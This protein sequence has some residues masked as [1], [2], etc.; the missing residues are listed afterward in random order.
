MKKIIYLIGLSI[1]FVISCAKEESMVFPKSNNGS[2][3]NTTR[4]FRDMSDEA[5]EADLIAFINK[6]DAP[7]GKAPMEIDEAL[8][9]IEATLNYKYVNLDYSKCQET[10]EFEGTQSIVPDSSGQLSMSAIAALYSNIKDDWH[11]KYASI[12]VE[13]KT[14]VAFDITGITNNVVNYVMMVGHGSLD[15][16]AYR[17]DFTPQVWDFI[18]AANNMSWRMIASLTGVQENQPRPYYITTGTAFLGIKGP[19]NPNDPTPGDGIIDY[20]RYYCDS[21]LHGNHFWL[22]IFEY[23]YHEAMYFS[24]VSTFV[25]ALSLSTGY[26]YMM[27]DQYPMGN[28]P[29]SINPIIYPNSA[30]HNPRVF[31]GTRHST[32]TAVCE[33]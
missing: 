1:I 25:S 3:T 24:D 31:Y 26:S 27:A 18:E 21:E 13:V 17:F 33:L 6:L 32:P 23:D 15:L 10:V 8:E 29:L 12:E 5:V 9:Y 28:F 19:I 30:W 16:P 4:L 22:E 2:M 7:E 20:H 11:D 14:P